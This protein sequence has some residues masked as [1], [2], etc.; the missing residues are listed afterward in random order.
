MQAA[1]IQ[2]TAD[3]LVRVIKEVKEKNPDF[4]LKRVHAFL[5]DSG[6]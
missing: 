3:E 1:G 2:P 5:T 4:G 6:W